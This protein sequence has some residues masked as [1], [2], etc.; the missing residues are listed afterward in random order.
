MFG[1]NKSTKKDLTKKVVDILK[2][3][4]TEETIAEYFLN[5]ITDKD[6]KKR[7]KAIGYVKDIDADFKNEVFEKI[8]EDENGSIIDIR[9]CKHK[10][11]ESEMADLSDYWMAL[12]NKYNRTIEPYFV[13]TGD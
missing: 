8:Y 1:E 10:P 3:S 4:I 6:N 12:Y 2:N 5:S 13:M 11:S 9:F 7:L